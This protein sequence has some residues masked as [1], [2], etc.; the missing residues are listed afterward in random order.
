[1]Q[2]EQVF[3]LYVTQATAALHRL[4]DVLLIQRQLNL[5]EE[6]ELMNSSL[7]AS[8]PKKKVRVSTSDDATQ[9]LEFSYY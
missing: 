2:Q 6:E 5:T 8:P 4:N 7:I 9:L 3:E 1:L